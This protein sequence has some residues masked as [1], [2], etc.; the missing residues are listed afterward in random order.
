MLQHVQEDIT[1][2]YLPMDVL[3][4]VNHIQW[5]VQTLNLV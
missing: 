1:Q 4:L 2:Q 5:L 3:V